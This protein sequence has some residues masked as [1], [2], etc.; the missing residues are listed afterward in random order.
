V[1]PFCKRQNRQPRSRCSITRDIRGCTLFF[2]CHCLS[3][4]IVRLY[5]NIRLVLASINMRASPSTKNKHNFSIDPIP[6]SVQQLFR[7]V[8]RDVLSE[9][10][11]INEACHARPTSTLLGPGSDIRVT[12]TTIQARLARLC[13]MIH[14]LALAPIV[15]C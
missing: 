14:V 4:E 9:L 11:V 15:P 12:C 2:L 3:C 7:D 13:L 10:A 8:S 5:V 6:P 1:I